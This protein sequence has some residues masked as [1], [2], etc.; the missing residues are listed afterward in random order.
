MNKKRVLKRI[1]FFLIIYLILFCNLYF[2]VLVAQNPYS[3]N[4]GVN[5]GVLAQRLKKLIPELM[6]EANVQGLSIAVVKD[7]QILWSQGFGVKNVETNEPVTDMTVFEAASIGKPVFA[8]AVMKLVDQ[9]KIDLDTPLSVY[10]IYDDIKHNEGY[11]KITARMVLTHT[12]GLPNWREKNQPLDLMFRPGDRFSYS[13][14][15]FIYLQKVV[16]HITQTPINDFME[17]TV[18]R[19]LGMKNSSYIWRE[20]FDELS[21][22]GHTAVGNPKQKQKPKTPKVSSSLHTTSVDYANFLIAVLN[23]EGLS[24]HIFKEMITPQVKLDPNCVICTEEN[25]VDDFDAV[26]WG[27]G[28]GLQVSAE[29]KSIWHWGDNDVFRCY[30]VTFLKQGIGMVY[31]TNSFNGLALR[32]KLVT[33]IVGGQHPA[34][35]WVEYE[36]YDSPGRKL[37]LTL[38]KE[39]LEKGVE[40]GR[41]MYRVMKQNDTEGI[42]DEPF[43]AKIGFR[44][45]DLKKNNLVIEVFNLN[46]EEYPDSWRVWDCLGLAYMINR[47][48]SISIRYYRKSLELNPNN[49][50][51]KNTIK[52]LESLPGKQ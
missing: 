5:R 29:G 26:S 18:F 35:S 47:E 40:S 19:P 4:I 28:W 30:T 20:N 2:R 36:Q 9:G 31:F 14:E 25:K 23:G 8:Y 10:W 48:N 22:T 32:D 34:F 46:A 6:S 43:L 50:R 37:Q 41:K 45:M 21:A 42:I 12:T 24:D 17:S 7:S 39:F 49:I 52:M 27:L 16:E 13:G 3:I 44:L 51:G 1:R 33:E 38:E 11:D 15:G